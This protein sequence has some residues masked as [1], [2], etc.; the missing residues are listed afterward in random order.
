M[1]VPRTYTVNALISGLSLRPV[2][3]KMKTP[4]QNTQRGFSLLELLVSMALGLIVP[5][6]IA[7][8]VPHGMTHFP[9]IATRRDAAE[10]ARR[11]AS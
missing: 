1:T 9:G 3:T 8:L 7:S 6:L 5:R 4:T 2:D 10:H 11:I